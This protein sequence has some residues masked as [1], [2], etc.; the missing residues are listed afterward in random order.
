MTPT[1]MPKRPNTTLLPGV[2]EAGAPPPVRFASK[3]VVQ[4]A[5]RRK[6]VHDIRDATLL[7]LVDA[8][9]LSWP[10]ARIP[11][12]DRKESLLLLLTVN[13]A[14]ALYLWLSR[15]IP[16]WRARRLAATWSPSERSRFSKRSKR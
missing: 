7:A 8:F 12:L 11:L 16:R 4:Q 6:I 14:L 3:G 5:R 15:T 13:V 10:R 9:F 1:P 2:D